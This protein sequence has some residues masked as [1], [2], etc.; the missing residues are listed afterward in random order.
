MLL[1]TLFCTVLGAGGN[2]GP[3][4]LA[5]PMSHKRY[6]DW[7]IELPNETFTAVGESIS[8]GNGKYSFAAGMEGSNLL[9]DL[10][11]DGATDVRVTDDEG[12]ALLRHED[13]FR[14]AIRLKRTPNGWYFASSGAQVGK[15]NGTKLALVDQNN[16]GNFGEVGVDAIIVGQGKIATWLGSTL[17]LDGQ[18]HDLEFNPD[19][20]Q[21][22]L[23]DYQGE[24]GSLSI[25]T[26]F[27]GQG[28]LLSA[29]VRSV[30]GKHC[31][32]LAGVDGAAQVPVGNYRIWSGKIG[33][34]EQAV[35]VAPGSAG[36]VSV[37]ASNPQEFS[38]GGPVRAEFEFQRGGD[39]IAFSPEHV[40]YYGSSGEEY[41]NWKPVGKSPVFK[42]IDSASKQEVAR[43]IFPG[44]C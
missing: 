40:W 32:D 20:H 22:E 10:D 42:V 26:G 8:L 25:A 44:S 21:L 39:Q 38:W 37:D 31:F 11:G 36:S 34:G 29:V 43:A 15:V 24:T 17:M 16:D 30:D 3:A 6:R 14:Y 5:V 7:T 33:L 35:K 19:A 18:L 1:E 9:L 28:K 41:V 4:D 27:N 13:G 23:G 12:S 2:A